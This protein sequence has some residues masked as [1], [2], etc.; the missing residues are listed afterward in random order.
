MMNKSDITFLFQGV[1][2]K[3]FLRGSFAAV[4]RY[5]PSSRIILSTWKDTD[6]S[7]LDCDEA[8]FCDDPGF[9]YYSPR[10]GEKPNNVNRQIVGTCAGLEKVTTP[11]CFRMRTDFRIT[12]DGFL[13]HFDSYTDSLEGYQ[14]FSHKLL[15]A[16]YFSRNPRSRVRFPFHPSDLAFFGYT[17]DIRKLFDIPLMTEEEACWDVGGDRYNRYTPEQHIFI[18]ALR[19]DGRDVPC[20]FYKDANPRAILETEKY[21]ASNFIFLTFDQ[22]NLMPSKPTFVRNWIAAIHSLVLSLVSR[23]K[24]WT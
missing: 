13:N 3:A 6:I 12:G 10:P 15:A 4:R 2:D 20:A 9:F 17:D 22:F 7:G 14:V 16:C 1:A 19:R 23:A 21:F 11:F 24:S 18:N 8:V 5:F